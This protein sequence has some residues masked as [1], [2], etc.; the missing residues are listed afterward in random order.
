MI[1]YA[2]Y[3]IYNF[4]YQIPADCQFL[5]IWNTFLNEGLVP[6]V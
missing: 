2:F 4:I 6:E 1:K 3:I 5:S